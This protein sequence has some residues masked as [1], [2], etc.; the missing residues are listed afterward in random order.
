MFFCKSSVTGVQKLKE[1]ITTYE[2][3]SGQHI[4]L[5]KSSITFSAKTPRKSKLGLKPLC[6]SKP[7]VA[8]GSISDCPSYSEERK[9]T[10]LHRSWTGLG[11]RLTVGPPVFSLVPES[12]FSS[13][14]CSRLCPTMLC[15]ASNS[16]LLSA[17]KSNPSLHASGGTLARTKG[18]YVGSLGPL[19]HCQSTQEGLAFAVWKSL[20]MRF[21]QRLDGDCLKTPNP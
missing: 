5:P 7:K 21:S 10:F 6:R 9:E 15:L 8:L 14:R 19:L 11:R 20:M 3:V 18:R 12:K 13:N 4:N 1:I 17:N 2:A 16:Q